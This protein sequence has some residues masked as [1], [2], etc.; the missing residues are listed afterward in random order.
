MQGQTNRGHA[1]V[2]GEIWTWL[3]RMKMHV[4]LKGKPA[5][6]VLLF[7]THLCK[8]DPQRPTLDNQ[9]NTLIHQAINSLAGR[10]VFDSSSSALEN[11]FVVPGDNLA[12]ELLLW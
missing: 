8:L 9:N 1:A 12:T 10:D 4:G 3:N 7:M 5:G 11:T 6:Y 2:S